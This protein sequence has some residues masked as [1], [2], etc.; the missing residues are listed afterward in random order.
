M[1]RTIPTRVL[2]LLGLLTLCACMPPPTGEDARFPCDEAQSWDPNVPLQLTLHGWGEG[3]IPTRSPAF[4]QGIRVYTADGSEVEVFV[5][6]NGPRSVAICADGG[7]EP[8]TEYRWTAGPFTSESHNLLTVE[9][10]SL[11]GVRSFT[12]DDTADNAPIV[13]ARACSGVSPS[14]YELLECQTDDT[15]DTADTGDSTP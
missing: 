11:D 6:Q 8:S 13:S 5:A 15:G 1:T 9:N 2:G 10:F 14:V 7:L 4:Q 3:S 12:T